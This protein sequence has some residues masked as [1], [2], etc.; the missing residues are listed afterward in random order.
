MSG[1]VEPGNRV[2][3]RM[4]ELSARG[5]TG[6]VIYVTQADPAPGASVDIVLAAAAG[7]ADIIELG[8]PF[9]DPNA[10]GPVIQRA[11]HRALGAGGG[12]ASALDT[13]QAIRARGC[14]VPIVLFGYYNPIF[15]YGV[16]AFAQRAAFAG[17]DA[18]LTVDLPVDELE[19]LAGPL[20]RHSI[21]VIPLL[22]PT[23]DIERAALVRKFAPPFVYYISMTGVT[24]AAFTG[25][26][27]GLAR[28]SDIRSATDAPVAVGFGI[29][30][31]AQAKDVA[32]YADAVVIGSAVVRRIESAEP[33]GEAAAVGAFVSEVRAAL[34]KPA[35]QGTG[36]GPAE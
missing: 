29:K 18:T 25:V 11:M 7:G 35:G 17:V 33:G 5:R 2:T 30:T 4:A 20:R 12:L 31:G 3:E 21:G 24:G 14:E 22:A 28:V 15:I 36:A 23:S 16:E 32:Q 10:D 9:S 27:D 19:E 1:S 8:V 26:A 34:D 6:L 13:V